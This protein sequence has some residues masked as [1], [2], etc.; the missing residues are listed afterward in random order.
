[1]RSVDPSTRLELS[2]DTQIRQVILG[3]IVSIL[4]AACSGGTVAP[5]SISGTA[6]P[7]AAGAKEPL[8]SLLQPWA[9]FP[10][11]ASPRP[12]VL[13]DRPVIVSA[14]F[15]FPNPQLNTGFLSGA[16][17][18]PAHLPAGPATAAGYPIISSD[19]A[20]AM[21]QFSSDWQEP[22]VSVP[23]TGTGITIASVRFGEGTFVTDRGP[24][25]LPAW[26]VS[27]A[28]ANGFVY[29][30]AVA[31]A[32][33]W[34]PPGASPFHY[35]GR[36]DVGAVI[37][38]DHRTLT[39]RFIGAVPQTGPCAVSYSVKLRESPTAVL[40]TVIAH[41]DAPIANVACDLV[42]YTRHASA[43]LQAP[44]G[45]RVVVEAFSGTAVAVTGSL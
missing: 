31:Q 17:D 36:S 37:A 18:R 44:L 7:S 40:L 13:V 1:M 34:V 26:L 10:V 24:K 30:L 25:T 39:A 35:V 11:D 23:T 5:S 21:L 9:T 27:P 14:G 3:G 4:L 43:V 45:N 15:G 16:F 33:R 42:G 12:I 41:Y 8:P 38:A 22:T 20:V 2:P 28:G 32:A 6:T 29:V 19:L